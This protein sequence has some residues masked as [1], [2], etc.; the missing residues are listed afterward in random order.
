[1]PAAGPFRL[2]RTFRIPISRI[3]RRVPLRVGTAV[4]KTDHD[5][6]S[7]HMRLARFDVPRFTSIAEVASQSLVRLGKFT[8][9]APIVITV[10]KP[11]RGSEANRQSA[12][13]VIR[14]IV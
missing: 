6:R 8:D 9:T 5:G 3:N 11:R 13:G 7:L 4:R 12:S 14:P 2:L 1:M 10:A